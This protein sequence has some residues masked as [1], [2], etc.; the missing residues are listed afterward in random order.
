[1]V[2]AGLVCVLSPHL[3]VAQ[4]VA[5]ALRAAG[6]P[7][8]ARSWDSAVG[9]GRLTIA[10]ETR[11]DALVVIVDGLDN[12]ATVD[13]VGRMVQRLGVRVVIVTS[14]DAAVRWG[15]LLADESVD[16]VAVTTSVSDLADVVRRLAAGGSS[17]DPEQRLAL[18]ASWAM[19]LDR[20]RQLRAQMDSLSPQQ[21]RVLELLASGRRVAEVGA[22]MGVAHGTVRS[23]V[24]ALR[25][26]LGAGT[27]LKA[28][29]MFHQAYEA[30]AADLV[31]AP[32]AMS[33][34][35]VSSARR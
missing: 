8:E 31:P 35:E 24:K 16:L 3:L 30:G 13:Q 29:A 12:P 14:A 25:A 21:R 33:H 32:R 26:K 1:M 2:E 22:E 7:A 4:A 6:L 20:R 27:Q 5:A 28:V 15:G 10:G 18:R 34:G 17:M 19:A 23:H 9:R 11:P